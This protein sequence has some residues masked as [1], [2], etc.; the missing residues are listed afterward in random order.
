MPPDLWKE[1]N[2][3]QRAAHFPTFS[4]LIQDMIRVRARH[5]AEQSR[6]I[7]YGR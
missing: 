7:G 5:D 4:D 2:A 3:Q 6:M 1:A